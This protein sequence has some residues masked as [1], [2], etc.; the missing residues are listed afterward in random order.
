M[1]GQYRVLIVDDEPAIVLAARVALEQSGRF[2]VIFTCSSTEAV[3][4]A[5]TESPDLILLD[6]MMPGLDGFEVCTL[7]KEQ[8]ATKN[9]PVVMLTVR[10]D[11]ISIERAFKA[12]AVNYVFK[13]FN[14]MV[15]AAR[16]VATLS[17][18]QPEPAVPA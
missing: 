16:L 13:P 2:E 7:L 17:K 6:I 4:I 11:A 15:L 9:I 3:R 8:A 5:E 18:L 1:S 12:G 10:T 14:A